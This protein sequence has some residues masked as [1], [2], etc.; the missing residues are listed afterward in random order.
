MADDGLTVVE[1][2]RVHDAPAR[3]PAGGP[4]G[5]ERDAV[6]RVAQRERRARRGP[7]W[8]FTHTELTRAGAAWVGVSA[9]Q[10][11]VQGAR[12]PR[13]DG[14]ARAG[15]HRP[16]A[17]RTLTHPGD[18]FS[19][20]IFTQA[21]AAARAATG[22]ILEGLAVERVIAVGESQS[23]FRLTTYANDIDPVDRSFDGYLVHA[24]GGAGAAAR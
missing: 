6:G 11:G 20:D 5:V 18:R 16:G 24:R 7:D 22:T 10:I 19:Y 21:G 3:V 15:R 23:A 1:E 17:V 2:A 14:V 13:R 9:Q 4:G 8:I 12:W